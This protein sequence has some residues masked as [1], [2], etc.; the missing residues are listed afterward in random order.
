M[1]IKDID[2]YYQYEL[3][4]I[5][6]SLDYDFDNENV[7]SMVR[8]GAGNEKTTPSEILIKYDEN[9]IP[10]GSSIEEIRMREKIISTFMHQWT[11]DNPNRYVF[12][13]ALQENIYIKGKSIAEMMQ[14]SS[15][16][17][18]STLAALQFAHILESAI[19]HTDNIPTKKGNSKQAEFDHMMI[20]AYQQEGFG[21]I[22]ITVGVKE[23]NAQKVQYGISALVEGQGILDTNQRVIQDVN[24][25]KK[26]SHQKR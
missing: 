18:K 4:N 13:H 12:N 9:G 24:K 8:D 20:L 21:T 15:K 3:L 19:L 16:R 1:E 26:A 23:S 11:L 22:K 7:M 6:W 5:E 2:N 14:H 17:Y 25:K 10:K